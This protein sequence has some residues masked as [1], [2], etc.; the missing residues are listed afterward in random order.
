MLRRWKFWKRLVIGLF[1]IPIVLFTTTVLIAFWKQEEIVQHF[2]KKANEDFEGEVIIQGSHVSPFANFPYISIDLE[3]LNIYEDK[4]RTKVPVIHVSDLYV[5]F[6]LWSLLGGNIEVKSIKLVDG[7]INIV[8]YE[9]GDY[10][11]VR[12]FETP[13]DKDIE[14]IESDFNFNLSELLFTNVDINK[15]DADSLE[16]DTYFDDAKIGFKTSKDHLYFSIDAELRL[17]MI[18]KGDTS[19]LRRKH[20]TSNAQFDYFKSKDSIL[21]SPST[22]NIEGSRFDFEGGIAVL[23][24]FNLD[25]SFSGRKPD[26][27]LFIA[28][29]PDEIIP[30]LK[31]FENRGDVFFE[32]KVKGKSINGGVP[33]VTADFG[34][35]KGF[36]RNPT[37]DKVL[38]ELSFT[39]HFT[40]GEARTLQ[41]MRFEINDFNAKPESGRFKVNLVVQNFESPDVDL[42][43]TTLFELD[44]LAEFLNLTQ[45]TNLKGRVELITNF[46]D[47]IDFE[48]P[49]KALE[50][51]NQSYYSELNVDNLEFRVPGYQR[52][53]RDINVA[54][55]V[56]GNAAN[57]EKFN[58][59]I[60]G[61]DLSITGTV[62]DLPAIIHHTNKEIISKLSI[63]SNA[64][65]LNELTIAADENDVYDEYIK[66]FSMDLAFISSAKALTESPYLPYGEFIISKFNADLTKYPHTLHD[67]NIDVIIDTNDI[68]VKDFSGMIDNSDFNLLADLKDYPFWFQDKFNGDANIYFNL[69]TNHFEFK[70]IFSYDVENFVPEDYRDEEFTQFNLYANT[71]LHF[72]EG[73][74]KSADIYLKNLSGKMK[75]HPL[76]LQDFGGR[77]HL[78][79]DHLTIEKLR[80]KMGNSS[81]TTDLVYYYG[82]LAENQKK[83][84]SLIFNA[85]RLDFDQL[86]NYESTPK[87]EPVDHDSVFSIFD[88]PFPDMSYSVK[89]KKMNYHKYLLE[90]ILA[91]LRTTKSHKLYIDTLQMGIAGGQ[92][93]V[94][95][96]FSGEDR[97]QIYMYPTIKMKNINLDKLMF[98]FDNFGQDEVLSDNLHGNISG[99]IWGKIHMHADLV[100]IIADSD[101]HMDIDIT[102][103]SIENYGPLEALSGY[104]EDESLHKIIFDT[105]QNHIDLAAG[106]MTVPEM[107]INTNLG[108]I[109]VSGKQDMDMNMEYYLKV[110]LKMIT[111]AGSKKLFGKNKEKK[112]PDELADYDPNKKYRFVNIK[113]VGDAEDYKVSLGKNKNK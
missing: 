40:N 71:D 83:E 100:P 16:F 53:I 110:P 68:K 20:I 46:H 111:S 99:K 42:Q 63:S 43:L 76:K 58:F 25:L 84:N 11:I 77:I 86:M 51:L 28:L 57:L 82:G 39:G 47:I 3:E 41:S 106:V 69:S 2:I 96:Y 80:G 103:G 61:S 88:I 101:I 29:A 67:F 30:V 36:F 90:D 23:D 8:E 5:G 73:D 52:R 12:A 26:F 107:V 10:N 85:N 108:F 109:V 33:Y 65:D 79:G 93:N 15:I 78:E 66:N 81:F 62:N 50:E 98:K 95:G 4:D 70:D 9:T 1:I 14:D 19:F 24:D 18:E 104:F 31:S 27:G 44:Y 45:L 60:G 38:D 59:K 75:V 89:I 35:D 22:L 54:L 32:A 6:D 34:C 113:I 55:K 37:T 7:D 21:I 105:L 91:E 92:M 56:D 74:L 72:I 112:S 17:S 102:G 64:V 49:E 97:T 48:N 87:G 13:K 94:G